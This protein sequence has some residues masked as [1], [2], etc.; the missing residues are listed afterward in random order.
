MKNVANI[1]WWLV[2]VGALNWGLEAL[3]MNLVTMLFGSWPMV[4]TL[5][6]S[7]VGLSAVYLV[8]QKFEIV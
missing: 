8:L 4:V 6:Y 2:I 5:V 3:G 1:A 7:L